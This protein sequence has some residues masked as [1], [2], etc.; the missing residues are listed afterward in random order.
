M[1]KMN[2]ATATRT[3]NRI[4]KVDDFEPFFTEHALEKMDL[5]TIGMVDLMYLLREGM[6]YGDAKESTQ[7]GFWKY[8]IQGRTPNSGQRQ[9]AAIVIPDPNNT[10]IK[11]ITVMWLDGT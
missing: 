4:A 1:P 11:V 6:V 3:I 10:F 7:R 2:P 8:Q 5:R 9:I